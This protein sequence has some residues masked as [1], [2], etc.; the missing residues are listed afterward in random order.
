METLDILGKEIEAIT[1]WFKENEMTVNPDKI[2]VMVLSRHKQK[3][4]IN[5]KTNEAEI[6]G[7]NAVIL[8]GV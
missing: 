8:L 4:I 1:K 2:K 6:E 7:P 5:L 3:E